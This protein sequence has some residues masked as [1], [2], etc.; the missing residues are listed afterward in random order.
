M[1]RVWVLGIFLSPRGKEPRPLEELG[2]ES[3]G[4][5]SAPGPADGHGQCHCAPPNLVQPL[6]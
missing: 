6:I 3:Q 1:D 2:L 5:G 4:G